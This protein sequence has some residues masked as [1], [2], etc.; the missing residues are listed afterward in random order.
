LVHI[1]ETGPV[2][3]PVDALMFGGF[4]VFLFLWYSL[5]ECRIESRAILEQEW[6]ALDYDWETTDQQEG[7]IVSNNILTGIYHFSEIISTLTC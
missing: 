3:S 1:D 2:R 6:V 7:F 4:F 5:S